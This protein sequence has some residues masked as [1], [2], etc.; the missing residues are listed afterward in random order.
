MTTNPIRERILGTWKLVS[1]VREEP[2]GATTDQF[3]PNPAGFINY[4][5]DGR[6]MVV[7]VRSDRQK[8]AGPVPTPEEAQALFNSVLAYGGAYT[9]DGNEITHHVDISWNETWTGTDQTRVFRF[10]GERLKLSTRPSPDPRTGAMS[11][12][13]MT[14]EKLK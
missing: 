4:A 6:M 11:V 3:G 9:I 5:P 1:V 12:R 8:P 14:W 7:N 2:S 13:T 10:E